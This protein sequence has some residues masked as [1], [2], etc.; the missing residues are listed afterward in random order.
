MYYQLEYDKLFIV[1]PFYYK[2]KNEW[3]DDLSIMIRFE[4]IF[5]VPEGEEPIEQTF[6][7][8]DTRSSLEN[9][10]KVSF[11]NVEGKLN[12]LEHAEIK[13]RYRV[14]SYIK[15]V[16]NDPDKNNS[17]IGGNQVEMTKEEFYFIIENYKNYIANDPSLQTT[18]YSWH[19]VTNVPKHLV[20]ENENKRH[21]NAF[22]E[23]MEEKLKIEKEHHEQALKNRQGAISMKS[24]YAKKCMEYMNYTNQLE[25]QK[26]FLLHIEDYEQDK[27]ME[28]Y[29][30][31]FNEW[32]KF[33][34]FI[35]NPEI[36]NYTNNKG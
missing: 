1:T 24:E 16:C 3:I 36:Y 8:K 32:H 6:Q 17:F 30:A 26:E 31:L 18:A 4:P 22:I 13:N 27:L 12:F 29:V 21:C 5:S 34:Q 35:S 14:V 15:G 10:V 7:L 11:D 28:I 20:I 25:N 9:L 23:N 19:E 33:T 2:E